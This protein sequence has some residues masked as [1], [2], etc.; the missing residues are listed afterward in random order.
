M[1]YRSKFTVAAVLGSLALPLAACGGHK[2]AADPRTEVPLV[3]VA[4]AGGAAKAERGFSGVVT[5]RVQSDLGFRVPGKVIERLV[6]AGQTVRRGQPLM[7]IDRTD[8]ALALD[9]IRARAQQTAADEKRYRDLVAVGAVSASAYDQIKA[10][11][12]AAQAQMRAAQNEANYALLVADADGVV[13]ET[14]AEPGQVVTAG[15]TVVRLAH[16]GAREAK[17][18]LPETVRP[19]IG[20]SA[21]AVL[22][23][24]GQISSAH[25]R[26]LSDAADPQ[27]RTF[28]AR[29]VLEGQAASA[30]LGATVQISLPD[31][32][33]GAAL[34]VPLAAIY[35]TGKGAG[36]WVVD[37]AKSVVV[38]RPV[39]LTGLSEETATVASGLSSGERFVAL[40]A[41]LLHAG[42]KVR[43]QTGAA[44]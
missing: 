43:V 10:A 40:G 25:L 2:E 4:T 15:Q 42:Q 6:D 29:Y 3:R 1:S 38:W 22:F 20:S 8:Y 13:V 31:T 35:D 39:Q 11:A 7:R 24:G 28:E 34:Q 26:L 12:D 16:A 36:V 33:S 17:I 30:P 23:D 5:A 37:P 9:A 14:L 41:H 44:Q 32:R 18:S 21:T 27:T 19:Q